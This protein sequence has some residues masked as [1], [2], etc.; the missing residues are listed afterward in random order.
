MDTYQTHHHQINPAYHKL[1]IVVDTNILLGGITLLEYLLDC[2]YVSEQFIICIPW[3]VVLELDGLRKSKHNERRGR[4]YR[5][6]YWI[7][8]VLKKYR[9]NVVF[10]TIEEDLETAN[11]SQNIDDRIFLSTSQLKEN[12]D[13]VILLTNDI[14]LQ[15]KA[16]IHDIH[17]CGSD[18][19]LHNIQFYI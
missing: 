3:G 1:C 4:A 14:N 7:N 9:K 2:Y 6:N 17:C 12:G 19:I 8:T 11:I 18:T 5:A 15:N 10:Q 16:A 13:N